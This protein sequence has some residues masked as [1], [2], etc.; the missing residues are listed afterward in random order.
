MRDG[1]GAPRSAPSAP[2]TEPKPV[3]PPRPGRPRMAQ[4][5]ARVAQL[6]E[7]ARSK[8]ES[9]P[10][11]SDRG[12]QFRR[13][14]QGGP[15]HGPENRWSRKAW[16]STLP[17]LL[18]VTESRPAR[19]PGLPAKECEPVPGLSFDYSAF[20]QQAPFVTVAGH[21]LGKAGTPV[22]SGHGAPEI[23]LGKPA[24]PAAGP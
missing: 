3:S 8:R 19:L 1:D 17:A 2:V 11:D 6:A 13:V 4:F 22:R 21:R 24:A 15:W 20:R 5:T 16:R 10:F 12:Y 9:C 23:G 14:N 7:A 18:H